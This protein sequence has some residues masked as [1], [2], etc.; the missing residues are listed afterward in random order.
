MKEYLIAFLALETF[1]IGVFISM[2]FILFYLFLEGGLIPMSLIIGIWG[3]ER[4]IYSTFKFFL[5]TLAGSVFMLLAVI[6]MYWEVGTSSIPILLIL[7]KHQQVLLS[8]QS[9]LQRVHQA[10]T[11]EMAT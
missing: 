6:F 4:R 2:D 3:G 11:Y 10:T 1:M 7:T 9:V 5:Y 8:L